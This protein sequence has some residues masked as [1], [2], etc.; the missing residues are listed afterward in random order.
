MKPPPSLGWSGS[1]VRVSGRGVVMASTIP[2]HMAARASAELRRVGL[3]AGRMSL[4]AGDPIDTIVEKLNRYQPTV[5]MVH[6]SVMQLLAAQQIAGRLKLTPG[7][8]QCTSEV[9]TADARSAIEQA[10]GVVPSNLYAASECGCLAAS[11]GQS[12]GLHF[13]WSPPASTATMCFR[14]SPSRRNRG[15]DP[16]MTQ[17]RSRMNVSSPYRQSGTGGGAL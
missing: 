3:D 11:C 15:V 8:I 17:I 13:V 4:D 9:L 5:M 10:F 6:P 2:W 1:N 7:H 16:Q 12:D 14:S